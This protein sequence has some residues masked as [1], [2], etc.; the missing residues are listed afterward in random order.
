ML[1]LAQTSL[2]LL[3]TSTVLASSDLSRRQLVG[4]AAAGLGSLLIPGLIQGCQ[5]GSTKGTGET[6]G[7]DGGTD[8][9]TE[10]VP[11]TDFTIETLVDGS[12]GSEF[13]ADL[14]RHQNRLLGV[15]TLDGG[16]G[17][18]QIYAL[19][20]SANSLPIDPSLDRDFGDLG[21][22]TL[23]QLAE[24]VASRAVVTSDDFNAG[25]ASGV[26]EFNLENGAEAHQALLAFPA[27]YN[28]GG[29]VFYVAGKLFVPTANFNPDFTYNP[30]TVLIYDVT[31]AGNI[32]AAS[33][34][35][36]ATS[37][38]NPTGSARLSDNRALVL[39]SGDFSGTA[40]ALLDIIDPATETI[41][42]TIDLGN[43]TAQVN[44]EIALT[45]SGQQAL[46]GSA[47][48][49]GRVLRVDI[50]TDTIETLVGTG[51]NFYSS[52]QV[53]GLLVYATDF[54]GVIDVFNLENGNRLQSLNLATG[55]AGP[56]VV[57]DGRLYQVAGRN[58]YRVTPV[59]D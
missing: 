22:R 25:G 37:G 29:G 8:A 45:E 15:S 7:T 55:N 21:T 28:F 48:G 34:R 41:E 33:L 51:T 59:Y 49:S 52:V 53:D 42:K 32:V 57:F 13:T 23:N 56:S 3:T 20:P 35:V 16:G 30:G 47:D 1:A 24:L 26:F 43:L 4:M 38:L 40:Q 9:G 58:V 12:L 27:E 5:D 44:G 10:F 19:D 14:D 18:N 36:F 46:I 50:E 2:T 39:N 31:D 6:G 11:P 17:A 54:S